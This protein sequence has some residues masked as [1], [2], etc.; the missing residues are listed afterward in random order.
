MYCTPNSDFINELKCEKQK[1][2]SEELP[3]ARSGMRSAA[4]QA[5]LKALLFSRVKEF[6]IDGQLHQLRNSSLLFL[7]FNKIGS[8]K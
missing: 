2:K 4:T 3:H 1:K 7:S 6:I 5:R 8:S